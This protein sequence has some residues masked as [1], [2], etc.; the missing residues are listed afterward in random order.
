MISPQIR[1][2]IKG[3][4]EGFVQGMI[5][6]HKPSDIVATELRPPK[7]YSADGE[8]KPFHEAMLPDGVLRITEFERSFST[9]LG[10]TFEECARLIATQRFKTAARKF[11]LTGDV[12]AAALSTID[13]ITSDI[14]SNG[15]QHDYRELTR[16][17]AQTY[18]GDMTA[19]KRPRIFDL[20]L[21]D[22]EGNEI[23][24]EMK[25]PKPN[26]DQCTRATGRL[27]LVHAIRRQAPKSVR[28]YYAMAYNPYG[29]RRDHYDHNFALRYLDIDNEVLIADEFWD[30]VGGPGT[31]KEVLE[32]YQEVGREK[33]PDIIANLLPT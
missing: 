30:L 1:S 23:Y 14:D 2:Q 29:D 22:F 4:I 28:T 5:D 6:D 3:Y 13:S 20:F 9:T 27:L 31:S 24:F 8:C 11:R 12:S 21:E 25:S 10:H 33:G 32:I 17:V 26:K 7:T 19:L 16:M 15:M 18:T